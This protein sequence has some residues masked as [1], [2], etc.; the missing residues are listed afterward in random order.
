MNSKRIQFDIPEDKL[1]ELDELKDRLGI[2]TRA[3]LLNDA[4]TLFKWAINERQTGNI[5]A[6]VNEKEDTYKEI[7]M[8]SF[9]KIF[10]IPSIEPIN[11]EVGDFSNFFR[12][13][14]DAV[15]VTMPEQI[16]ASTSGDAVSLVIK[17][18]PDSTKKL[19]KVIGDYSEK[20]QAIDSAK[21]YKRASGN[22]G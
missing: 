15:V 8:A 17:D 11:L 12:K 5:I 10:A 20:Q 14:A 2:K 1:A 6:A 16:Q 7:Q 9:P 18:S 21:G 13:L 4:I 19:F 3:A 22:I